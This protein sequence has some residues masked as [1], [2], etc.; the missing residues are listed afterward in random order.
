MIFGYID[1][2]VGA[3]IAQLVVAGTVGVG[4]VLKLKWRSIRGFF[5]RDNP[6]ANGP[7]AGTEISS[8]ETVDSPTDSRS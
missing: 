3:T 7:I 5:G 8:D 1:P 6:P 4:A 2:A